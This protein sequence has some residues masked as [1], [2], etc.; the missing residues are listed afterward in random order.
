[1][2]SSY[3]LA[4]ERLA[5]QSPSVKLTA[6][7]KRQIAE[8]DSLYRARFA[9]REIFLRGQI[10]K[11]IE[12]GDAEEMQQLERQILADRRNLESECEDKKEKVR[13]GEAI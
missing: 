8:L 3:E 7:Q 1:M 2:K 11:A 9:E 10:E 6:D 4:M 13:R 5:K 12:K